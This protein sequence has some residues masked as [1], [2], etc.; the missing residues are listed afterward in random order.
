MSDPVTL[1]VAAAVA[2]KIGEGLVD[3]ATK[4]VP[5]L[6][7]ALRKLFANSPEDTALLNA[8]TDNVDDTK[9]QTALAA[10]LAVL[11]AQ[12]P[13][14]RELIATMTTPTTSGNVHNSLSG[15]AHGHV[16]QIGG[17]IQG[18]VTLGHS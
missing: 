8:V 18:D 12:D 3:G 6:R 4:L 10:R 2:G 5:R 7:K 14:V 13:E 16:A 9:S 1:A 11:R 15:T 17:D